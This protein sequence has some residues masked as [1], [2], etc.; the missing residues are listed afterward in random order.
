VRRA[1]D[2]EVAVVEGR[3][4]RVPKSFGDGDE[5]GVGKVQAEVGIVRHQLEAALPVRRGQLGRFELTSG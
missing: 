4:R 3:D 1:N 5:G 2:A